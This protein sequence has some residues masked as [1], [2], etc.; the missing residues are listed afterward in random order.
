MKKKQNIETKSLIVK[1]LVDKSTVKAKVRNNLIQLLTEMKEALNELVADYNLLLESQGQSF[2]VEMISGRNEFE[3][4]YESD[5]LIFNFQPYVFEFDKSH[6]VW[7]NSYVEDNPLNAFAGIINIYNFLSD[8]YR[9]NKSED[10][11]YLIARIF[12]NHEMHYFVEGKR[13]L[14]FLYNDYPT[15]VIHKNEFKKIIESAILYSLD[16]EMLVPNY[17]DVSIV[18]VGQMKERL[19]NSTVQTGKRLGFKFYAD[20]VNIH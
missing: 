4:H 7:T 6:P 18:S 13:Q 14:G 17:D 11:G 10:L 3:L 8:S 19:I 20:D 9:N 2:R 15:A 16:F 5:L 1:T 12:I